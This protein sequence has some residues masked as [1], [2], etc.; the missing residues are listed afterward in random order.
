MRF[1][2]SDQGVGIRASLVGHLRCQNCGALLRLLHPGRLIWI[3]IAAPLA[4]I[5][6]FLLLAPTLTSL[7]GRSA[8]Q[9]L[10]YPVLVAGGLAGIYF[11][12]K[13]AKVV[14]ISPPTAPDHP[15]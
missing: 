7:F 13:R 6:M 9:V 3:V 2:F 1:V 14:L 10:F 8:S 5:A 12:W 4:S 15:A 11:F